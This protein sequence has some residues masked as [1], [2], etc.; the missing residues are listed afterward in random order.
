MRKNCYAQDEVW[1]KLQVFKQDNKRKRSALEKKITEPAEVVEADESDD[2]EFELS[3]LS[4][5]D[6]VAID[7]VSSDSSL[8][9]F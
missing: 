1:S 5:E 8:Q 9:S 6:S 3:V 7:S 2:D 4:E